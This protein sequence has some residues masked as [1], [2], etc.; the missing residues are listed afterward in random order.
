MRQKFDLVQ[1]EAVLKLSI[2]KQKGLTALFSER[3]VLAAL[4]IDQRSASRKLFAAASACVADDIPGESLANFKTEVS[5]LLTPYA[6]E[7][8]LDPE[9]GLIAAEH[10]DSHAGPLLAYEKTGYDKSNPGKLPST[11]DGFSVTRLKEAGADAVKVL[12]YYSPFSPAQINAKKYAWVR[13][14]SEKCVAAG[15]AFF[16][17]IV[18]YHHDMDEKGPE[19]A[20]VKP[21][22]VV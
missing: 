4:A 7:I 14:V 9:Y 5:K 8:L 6:S 13:R 16:L 15:V 22:V 18:S 12:L 3:G 20:L 19:F 17:E 11:L 2:W 1:L 21:H 10:R